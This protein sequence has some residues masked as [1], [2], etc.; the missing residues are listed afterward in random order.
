MAEIIKI[1]FS[2]FRLIKMAE[3]M[4]DQ[5][6]YIDALKMLNKS[7]ELNGSSD[8]ARMLYAEIFD[9]MN[10]YEKC[11][12]GWFRYIDETNDDDLSDCYEGIAAAF[13]NIGS[14]NYS[15][16]YYHLLLQ[17]T[18]EIDADTREQILNDFLGD[19]EPLKFAYPPEI[20]D[21]TEEIKSGINLMKEE[22][23]DLAAETFAQVEERNPKYNTARN[24]IAMC[25]I[26]SDK[27]DEAEAECIEIL[28]RD[29]TNVQALTTLAAVQ[30]EK[31]NREEA[32]K[33]SYELLSLNLTDSDDLYKVA[34]VCCENKLHAEAYNIFRKL[35]E[36]EELAYD[37]SVMFFKAVSAFNCG[38]TE[39]SLKV[40]D[41]IETIYPE[42]ATASYFA[43]EVRRMLAENEISELGYFYRLPQELREQHFKIL[44]A[45]L[46]LPKSKAEKLL[47][48]I[49][50][51]KGIRWC[52]D[53]QDGKGE[54]LKELAAQVAVKAGR[55]DIVREI[56]LNAFVSDHVKIGTLSLLAERNVFDSFGIVICC[57]Y[58]RVSTRALNIRVPKRKLFIRAYAKLVAHFSI[59]DDI[60]GIAFAMT[61]EKLYNKLEK[62]K[63]LDD[64]KNV[65]A[66]AAAI[67][68]KS[69]IIG[70]GISGR[71][72]YEFFEVT[73]NQVN[74]ILG[75]V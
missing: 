16:Y 39:E 6:K 24:Y 36:G 15:A 72:V 5:H 21:R 45:F 31:G 41:E 38:K 20:A 22:K 61:A 73:E 52:F 30:S 23:Y 64:V 47:E 35:T 28:K 1:D 29:K 69:K 48:E 17:E 63:R 49:D 70:A 44:A 11:I 42:A 50:V 40:F 3:N 34:T 62:E 75:I 2:D 67:Y 27:P 13:M 25:K 66:L 33:L 55:D 53:E 58:K 46:Q 65:N 12:N 56:L 60:N 10:L 4:V 43:S 26:I 18:D 59:L 54:E 8:R 7:M 37:L 19:D 74:K 51:E 32:L 9:D 71:H 57:I 68:L 14:E